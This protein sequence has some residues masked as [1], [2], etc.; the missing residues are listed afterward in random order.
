M[1]TPTAAPYFKV[2]TYG[3]PKLSNSNYR[4]WAGIMERHLKASGLWTIVSGTWQRPE[5]AIL[6][7]DASGEAIVEHAANKKAIEE[8][9]RADATAGVALIKTMSPQQNALIYNEETARGIW[10]AMQR[11]HAPRTL[12][13]FV[14][15]MEQFWRFKI[16]KMSISQAVAHLYTLRLEIS[17][18]RPGEEP[19]DIGMIA[20]L[21]DAV[22]P[23]FEV[24]KEILLTDPNL[25][26]NLVI[27][28]LR[29]DEMRQKDEKVARQRR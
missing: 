2:N 22:G 19:N 21:L 17:L 6:A 24:V 12:S 20:V 26:L 25:N 16:G 4:L 29:V 13:R 27:S 11:I 15:L 14:H 3:V 9:E 5:S 23:E 10:D 18:I 1:T 28:S 8:W 7:K